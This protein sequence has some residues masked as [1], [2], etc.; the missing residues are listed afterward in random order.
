MFLTDLSRKELLTL[1]AMDDRGELPK[2]SEQQS[3]PTPRPGKVILVWQSRPLTSDTLPSVILVDDAE[4]TDFLAWTATYLP[5]FRPLTALIRVMGTREFEEY[6]CL[7]DGGSLGQLA[8]ATLGLVV[9][10]AYLYTHGRKS[11]SELSANACTATLSFSMTRALALGH[12]RD[13]SLKIEDR[14]SSARV[15]TKQSQLPVKPE[16]VRLPWVAVLA[17]SSEDLSVPAHRGTGLSKSMMT[18]CFE[19]YQTK[20]ISDKTWR[21]LTKNW[22]VASGAL[23]EMSGP[24]EDRVK[25]FRR[26]VEDSS[27]RSDRSEVVPMIVGYLASRIAPGSLDHIDLLPNHLPQACLWYGLFA[28]LAN[29]TSVQNF[30]Q[31]LGLRIVRALVRRDT[32]FDKPSCDIS[33]RELATL[34]ESHRNDIGVR[35]TYPGYIEIELAP[36]VNSV[37]KTRTS[38]VISKSTGEDNSGQVQADMLASD[39]QDTVLRLE[40]SFAAMQREFDRLAKIVGLRVARKYGGYKDKYR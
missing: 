35:T 40:R 12:S 29:S 3:I 1:L 13:L 9:C 37:L 7:E 22:K 34:S 11:L 2:L 16:I 33:L 19:S 30:G 38:S 15:L 14:W 36:G 5:T 31:G 39:L 20:K 24:R 32:V 21:L 26:A 23:D 25:A 8:G 4:L 10:E 18:A 27:Q 17:L 28:G 6:A